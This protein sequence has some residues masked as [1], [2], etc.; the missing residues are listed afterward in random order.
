[1]VKPIPMPFGLV[2][3][4]CAENPFWLSLRKANTMIAHAHL[5]KS[6]GGCRGNEDPPIR[7]R[8]L[9]HRLERIHDQIQQDLLQM[10]GIGRDRWKTRSQLSLDRRRA[11]KQIGMQEPQHFDDDLIQINRAPLSF[12]LADKTMDPVNDVARAPRVCQN[13]LQQFLEHFGIG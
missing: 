3:K 13:I 5:D 9:L 11:P 4:K 10:D 1:M 6:V 7:N 8:R 2:E 12:T